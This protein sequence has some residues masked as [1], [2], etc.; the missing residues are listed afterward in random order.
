MKTSATIILFLGALLA[1]SGFVFTLQGLGI[2]GPSSSFM[3]QSGS[4]ILYGVIIFVVG[5]LM[6]GV[7]Y[8]VGSR[9]K[10]QLKQAQ[11]GTP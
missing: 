4:W 9:Q 2:V 11:T 5:L 8:F 7:G 3:Y 10:P 1:L 6:V